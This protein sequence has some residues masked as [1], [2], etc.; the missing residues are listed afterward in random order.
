MGFGQE[1]AHSCAC[2]R[3]GSGVCCCCCCVGLYVRDTFREVRNNSGNSRNEYFM[4]KPSRQPRRAS[5][6]LNSRITTRAHTRELARSH[7]RRATFV[8]RCHNV[9]TTTTRRIRSVNATLAV[10]IEMNGIHERRH[11]SNRVGGLVWMVLVW[12]GWTKHLPGSV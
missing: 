7:L 2:C 4:H 11:V 1:L 6:A 5:I 9:T 10:S 12:F 8:C 3:S